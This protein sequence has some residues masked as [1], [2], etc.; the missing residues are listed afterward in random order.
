MNQSVWGQKMSTTTPSQRQN[1]V[2]VEMVKFWKKQSNF[3]Q[4]SHLAHLTRKDLLM[5]ANAHGLQNSDSITGLL[6]HAF[7]AYE[8]SSEETRC[9]GL[10]VLLCK[11]TALVYSL[12]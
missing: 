3:Y 1:I 4:N 7:V 6:Y 9:E 10:S 11:Q 2:D 12:V 5:I 8:S